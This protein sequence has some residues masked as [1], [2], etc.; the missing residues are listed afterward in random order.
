M[1]EK[2][3]RATI[4][5]DGRTGCITGVFSDALDE[6]EHA[7]A[8][9]A[10]ARIMRPRNWKTSFGEVMVNDVEKACRSCGHQKFGGEPPGSRVCEVC[11]LSWPLENLHIKDA[12][13]KL[14]GKGLGASSL[15]DKKN[16]R[17]DQGAR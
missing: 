8:Q 10:L 2:I 6:K 3:L 1:S 5:I 14:R 15:S 4:E 11:R 16:R 9:Q 12:Q 17:T 13:A 7:A